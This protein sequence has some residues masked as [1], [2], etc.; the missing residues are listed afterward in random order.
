MGGDYDQLPSSIGWPRVK[1]VPLVDHVDDYIDSEPSHH[2]PA[3]A[4]NAAVEID[5]IRCVACCVVRVHGESLSDLRNRLDLRVNK[6]TVPLLIKL[7]PP[8]GC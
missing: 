1:L 4:L 2:W 3:K 5:V 7:S 8:D 6:G